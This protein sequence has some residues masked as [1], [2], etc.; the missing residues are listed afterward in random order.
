MVGTGCYMLDLSVY[1]PPEEWRVDHQR[2][3][4]NGVHW[5]VRHSLLRDDG[6]GSR[7]RYAAL[8]P[9]HLRDGCR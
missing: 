8:R 1:R 3:W 6:W 9:V 2:S 7:A 4:A 5:R